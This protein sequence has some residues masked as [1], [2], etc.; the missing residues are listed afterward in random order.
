MV[1]RIPLRAPACD[2]AADPITG[3][4]P[5]GTYGPNPCQTTVQQSEFEPVYP[6]NSCTASDE[7]IVNRDATGLRLRNRGMALTIVDPTYNGD[8]RCHGD[9]GGSLVDVPLVPAGY[10]LTFRQAAGFAPKA[11]KGITPSFPVKVLRG[12][13]ESIW[14]VDEGDFISTSVAQASTRGKVYRVESQT[15][16]VNL[17]E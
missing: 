16:V 4:L 8:L 12:P 5:D 10:Q 15:L 3:L 1:G 17:L 9:R 7:T 13:L 14:I 2:P 11:L 6:A